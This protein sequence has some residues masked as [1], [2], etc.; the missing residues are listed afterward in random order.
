[1]TSLFTLVPYYCIGTF[2]KNK[3]TGYSSLG[4]NRRS[5]NPENPENPKDPDPLAS[6]SV[7]PEPQPD[8]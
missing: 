8:Q 2:Q 1:M 7:T 4:R 5:E 3:L 6:L